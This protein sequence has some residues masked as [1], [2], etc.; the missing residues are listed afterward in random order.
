MNAEIYRNL[1]TYMKKKDFCLK[2]IQGAISTASTANLRLIYELASMKSRGM[3]SNEVA[4]TMYLYAYDST[5]L[6]AK[7]YSDISVYRKFALK[8]QVQPSY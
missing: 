3:I 1:P 5:K 6:L 2:G 7:G 4:N 8:S